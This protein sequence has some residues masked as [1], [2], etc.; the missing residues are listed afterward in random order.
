[1]RSSVVGPRLM[2]LLGLSNN[3]TCY[4]LQPTLLEVI[5]STV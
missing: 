1:M 4:I 2:M 5:V 3:T